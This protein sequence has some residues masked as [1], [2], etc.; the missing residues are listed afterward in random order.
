MDERAVRVAVVGLGNLGRRFVRILGDVADTVRKDHGVALRLVAVADARGWAAD[1]EGLA[2]DRVLE[3]KRDGGSVGELRPE[4]HSGEALAMIEGEAF[5]VLCEATPV[6][7]QHGGEPGLGHVRAALRRGAH[8][9]TPNKGPIVLAWR[10]LRELA[11]ANGVALRFDGT[12]A[13]GLPALY[14]GM[15]DLR[16]ARIDRIEAVPNLTS[17]LVLELVADGR[18]WEEALAEA[19]RRGALEADPAWDVDGWDAA[20]KLVILANAVLGA[21]ARIE[22][23]RRTGIRGIPLKDA[24]AARRAGQIIRLVAVAERAPDGSLDLTVAPRRLGA[25]HPLSRL[26]R[27]DMGVVFATDLYGTIT[28]LINEPTPIPSAATMLRDILDIYSS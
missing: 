27:D 1:A 22:D 4:G 20:A 21:E 9:V 28:M 19:R 3:C 23:V 18:S 6:N 7:I 25:P 24:A 11:D 2:P 26:G 17:G 13:G 15:R 10:E 16:G 12:V 14:T 8:V 5:D